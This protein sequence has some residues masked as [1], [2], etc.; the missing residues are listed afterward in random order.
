MITE[1]KYRI[2]LETLEPF[3]IGGVE[4]PL[5]GIHNPVAQV[6]SKIVVPGPSLKGAL[7]A[8]MEK[9]LI[10]SYYK[11]KW[12]EERRYF[13]PCI[14]A[15]KFSSDEKAL[16]DAGKYK[17]NA[18]RYPCI[19]KD[20][21][22]DE[23]HYICPVCYFFGAMGLNGFV[24]I[25]FLNVDISPAELYAARVDRAKGTVVEGTNRPYQL[26]PEGTKFAGDLTI[27][28]D[29][30]LLGWKLG[31]M[32][33]LKDKTQGDLWLKENTMDQDTL[34]KTYILERL[35]S[36]KLLGG[37]KSKGFGEVKIT[38]SV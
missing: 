36:I 25:P 11:E 4:D 23:M 14:P 32:R 3:R 35:E 5:S 27:I 24:R 13:K 31:A 18:C 30:S 38:V 22:Q 8:E 19:C 1:K 17:K 15:T 10:D 7:R 20:T 29:D 6:G 16:I 21:C 2:E 12:P 26:I 37:Y 9:F 34:I 28:T 33:D